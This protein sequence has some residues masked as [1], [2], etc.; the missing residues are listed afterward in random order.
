MKR[1]LYT[2]E[3]VI[4]NSFDYGE[5]DR[6]L[7]FCTQ[8]HGKIKGIAKGARRSRRRFVGN[9]EPTSLV[10]I[11]F[12]HS[13]RSELVRIE[14]ATLLEGFHT[15]K[16]DIDLLS[17][18]CYF[19][20][21][22]SELT[23]EGIV[24]PKVFDLLCEFLRSLDAGADPGTLARFFEVRLLSMLGYLPH[25]SGCIVCEETCGKGI[26]GFS[27]ERGGVVCG[28]CSAGVGGLHPISPA[29]AASLSLAL[30]L[31]V[32]KL[33]R[34]KVA[35]SFV[36]ESERLLYDFIKHQIGKE[37]KTKKFLDKMRGAQFGTGAGA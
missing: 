29:T 7:T 20:E 33:C 19:V 36:E 18:G 1:G 3:A 35:P 11:V 9:L 30:K 28:P 5:S 21:L 34:L 12:F 13:E 32:D 24:L 4:L 26:Q 17:H 27:S 8:R 10:R 23:R 14:D 16:A 22:T 2:T 31:D 37:L 25:L 6:I 15:L